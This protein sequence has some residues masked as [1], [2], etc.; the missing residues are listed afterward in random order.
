[1][2]LQIKSLLQCQLLLRR[3]VIVERKTLPVGIEPTSPP[4]ESETLS[5]ELHTDDYNVVKSDANLIATFCLFLE[6][7]TLNVTLLSNAENSSFFK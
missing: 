5:A 4:S 7:F 3:P 2:F 1:M 6:S